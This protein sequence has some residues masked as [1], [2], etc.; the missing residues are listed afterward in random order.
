MTNSDCFRCGKTVPS[1]RDSLFCSEACRSDIDERWLKS[2]I[3]K[4][5]SRATLLTAAELRRQ[6]PDV[7]SKCGYPVPIGGWPYCASDRNPSG[8]ARGG[9]YAWSMSSPIR[10]WTRDPKLGRG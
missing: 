7:C 5:F 2:E 1:E 3:S 9:A 6:L 4:G 10:K 8:H